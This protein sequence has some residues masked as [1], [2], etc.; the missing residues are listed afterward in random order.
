MKNKFALY[1]VLFSNWMLFSNQVFCQWNTDPAIDNPICVQPNKQKN[2]KA[3]SDLKGGVIIVWEDYRND[4]ILG[5]IYAQR[6]NAAGQIVWQTNGVPIC[7]N[8]ADQNSPTMVTDSLG[9]AFIVWQDSRGSKQ[10]LYAQRIDSSGNV[11]WTANGVGVTLRNFIQKVPKILND[12]HHGVVVVWEDSLGASYNIYAQRLDSLGTQLWT[13]GVPICTQV[14]AQVN[15]K[16]QINSSGDTY[17]AWQDKRNGADYDIYIQKINLAGTPQWTADG[18]NI[19]NVAGTQSY[20]RVA[21][22]AGG[23]AI[24]LWQDKRNGL[25]YDIYAQ[26]VNASGVPQWAANGIGIC[27]ATGSQT[28][29]DFTTTGISNGAIIAWRDARNGWNNI[30]VYAQMVDLNGVAQWGSN[31]KAIANATRNQISVSVSNDGT[32]GAIMSYQDSSAGTWDI[33]AQRVSAAGALLWGAGGV[34]VGTAISHQ[35]NQSNTYVGHNNNIFVFEDMRSGNYDIYAYRIDM[36]GVPTGL[37]S[38]TNNENAII[39]YPNPSRDKVTFILPDSKQNYQ[40][41]I[42]NV[43]GK[44]ILN[45]EVFNVSK[46]EIS[47]LPEAGIFFYMIQN[48]TGFIKSG[49]FIITN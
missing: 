12:R 6:I 48:N 36:N 4:T 45:E 43:N 30:D 18:I 16:A 25:D 10:N 5:D 46:Y 38:L 32:G 42:F 39:V 24:V 23:D 7:T 2:A 34:G 8:A 14:L 31:G 1:M 15:P 26:R 17:I 22:D 44:E 27:T 41:K 19:C 29:A 33:K 3:V 28:T 11:K 35:T 49:K 21:I 13:G 47:T 37:T 40:I 20:A 9:G